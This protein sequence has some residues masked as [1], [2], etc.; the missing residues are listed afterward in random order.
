MSINNIVK[1]LQDVM[2]NDAGINGDAQRIEQMVWILF[3]KVYDAKEENWEFHNDKFQSIIPV[4]L[5]WRN[6]AKDNKDGKVLT[7]ESL[8]NFVNTELF[9][10]LKKLEVDEHTPMSK[11]IVKDTFVDSFNYMKDGVLLRQVVNIIDEIDFNEYEDRHAFGE[12]YETILK[13]LQ[14]AGNAGEFYTPSGYSGQNDQSSPDEIDHPHKT[15]P[16]LLFSSL[17]AV[18]NL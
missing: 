13:D 7:G 5:R 4:N 17:I 9:P 2:R 10:S 12:I 14:S 15:E 11:L 6:W 1:R 18:T 3:L 8:L 16:E